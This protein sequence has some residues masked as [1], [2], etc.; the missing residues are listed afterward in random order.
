MVDIHEVLTNTSRILRVPEECMFT[1]EGFCDRCHSQT[2]EKALI[3][4][5]NLS[6]PLH[7]KFR[8]AKNTVELFCRLFFFQIRVSGGRRNERIHIINLVIC[9][10]MV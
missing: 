1:S 6:F 2:L 5:S 9:H 10:V 3:L 4:C 7:F 8:I